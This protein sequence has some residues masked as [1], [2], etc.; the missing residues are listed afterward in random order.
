MSFGFGGKDKMFILDPFLKIIQNIINYIL[1]Y[2]GGKD[3][4][5]TCGTLASTHA[6]Q[7]CALNHSATFPHK[8]SLACFG[9]IL[10]IEL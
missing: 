3:K 1:S 2:F 10:K 7:A 6:F 4:I 9:F 5:R 8:T